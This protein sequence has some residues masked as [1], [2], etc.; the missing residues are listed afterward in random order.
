V[1]PTTTSSLVNLFDSALTSLAVIFHFLTKHLGV[2]NH[3]STVQLHLGKACLSVLRDVYTGIFF[4]L[5]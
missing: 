4:A 5:A 1:F 2:T 3:D